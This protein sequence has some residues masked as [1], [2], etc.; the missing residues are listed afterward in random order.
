MDLEK[1]KIALRKFTKEREWEK[2]HNPKNLATALSVEASE[3]LGFYTSGPY[4][5]EGVPILGS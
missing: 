4:D 1:V 3:L 2:F 5:D